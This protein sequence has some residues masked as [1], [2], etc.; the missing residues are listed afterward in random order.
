VDA[1]QFAKIPGVSIT[2]SS[3]SRRPCGRI[4]FVGFGAFAPE[5]LV[6]SASRPYPGLFDSRSSSGIRG[7]LPKRQRTAVATTPPPCLRSVRVPKKKNG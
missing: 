6:R 4:W 3:A 7:L 1:A 2:P 5:S